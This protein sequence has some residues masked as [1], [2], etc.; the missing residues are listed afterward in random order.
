MK[1]LQ[2]ITTLLFDWDGTLVDSAPLGL[3]AFQKSFSS[4]GI[5]FHLPTYETSY[6]PNWYSMYEA[7]GV[8]KEQ[9]KTADELWIQYYGEQ[10]ASLV[11]GARETIT[12]LHS[13]G[14]KLA[15]VSSG[16]RCRVG[17]ELERLGL[18][19]LFEVMVCNEQ[20]VNKKPHPEGL[21]TALA[22]L[23]RLPEHSC[24]VGDSPEDV[25][26]GKKA[27]MLTIG[28]RS[29]Y[30]TNW[31]LASANPDIYLESLTEL[32]SLFS[33]DSSRGG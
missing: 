31:R 28:V 27:N 4:M 5:E 30:P 25:E 26:M 33:A 3:V 23:N 22:L 15:I 6:S 11:E 7:M 21:E 29:G 1:R 18:N 2:S 32:S 13:N 12:K 24:Y 8:P 16:S 9:W 10:T 19:S 17:R 20:M 14:F